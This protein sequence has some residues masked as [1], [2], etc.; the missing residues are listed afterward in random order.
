MRLLVAAD[1]HASRAAAKM[2]R[3]RIA[4]HRPDVFIAAGDLTNFG[5]VS[6]A[7][8]LLAGIPV[9]TLAVPGN[10]DPREVVPVL[11]ELGVD[12][13][14]KRAERMGHT[15]VGIGGSNPTPFG[16]PFELGEDEILTRVRPLMKPGAVLISH[17]PPKGYVDIVSSGEHVGS[18][19]IRTIVEEF[20]PSL[21]LCGHIHEARGIAH[22]GA[23]TIVNPGPAMDGRAAVV[24]I[25]R[26]EVRVE[27]L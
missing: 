1:I 9:P 3:E 14:G 12:L 2:I 20:E 10:C 23:T 22:H 16:T 5:P 25:D 6:F 11:D 24:S 15:F 27:L 4:E 13:H 21:V 19:S 17:A 8:E 26:G 7:R 18:T